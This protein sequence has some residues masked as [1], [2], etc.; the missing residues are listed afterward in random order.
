MAGALLSTT[1]FVFTGKMLLEILSVS[2]WQCFTQVAS[3]IHHANKQPKRWLLKVAGQKAGHR[4]NLRGTPWAEGYNQSILPSV[5]LWCC[6]AERV[7]HGWSKKQIL[8]AASRSHAAKD[9][10]GSQKRGVH[11]AALGV[12]PW[13]AT[14][15]NKLQMIY[16]TSIHKLQPSCSQTCSQNRHSNIVAT[17]AILGCWVG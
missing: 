7:D 1:C 10:L 4:I 6:S 3:K 12:F 13:N 8:D 2:H 5:D 16:V 11:A 9:L 17:T 14:N 15:I